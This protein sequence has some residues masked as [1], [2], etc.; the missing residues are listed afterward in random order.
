MRQFSAH[1][2]TLETSTDKFQQAWSNHYRVGQNKCNNFDA[3]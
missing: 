2:W 3:L 1:R